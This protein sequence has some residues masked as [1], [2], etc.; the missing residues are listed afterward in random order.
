M[1]LVFS[2]E[3][4]G[5]MS[6]WHVKFYSKYGQT[7]Q[8]KEWGNNT[9]KDSVYFKAIK[10]RNLTRLAKEARRILGGSTRSARQDAEPNSVSVDK[11]PKILR[12]D[13]RSA[14]ENANMKNKVSSH[15]ANKVASDNTSKNS[16]LKDKSRCVNN[17]ASMKKYKE[18]TFLILVTQ[19]K[20]YVEMVYPARSRKYRKVTARLSAGDIFV[21]P[22]GH[23][24]TFV[25]SENE[26]LRA[27]GFSLYNQDNRRIFIA[28]KNNMV[29]HMDREAKELSF[30]APSRLVD[31]IFNKPQESYLK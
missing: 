15:N 17:V 9:E 5:H 16:S 18:A 21:V 13:M 3:Q 28:G 25:A 24:F 30:G 10:G 29:R 19:G 11:S 2:D 6:K 27:I 4:D 1:N 22:A 31:E 14:R 23:P 26:N 8:Q 20:G 12:R 7:R